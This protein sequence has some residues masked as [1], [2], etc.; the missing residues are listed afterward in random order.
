AASASA[1]FSIA[2]AI[3]TVASNDASRV[4]GQGN[5]AFSATI[6]GFVN[7]ETSQ[8]VSGSPSLSTAATL[9]SP[10]GYSAIVAG[11]GTL[12]AA[13]YTFVFKNG[14]LTVAPD[15]T[16]TAV[17][18]TVQGP[19]VGLTATVSAGAPGSGTP[20]GSVDF[21]DATTGIDLGSVALSGGS[22]TLLTS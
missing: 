5:P 22:A 21:R 16:N 14:T 2:P 1:T 10:V 18:A 17:T 11:Q 8:V 13:N 4:F 19:S 9:N 20:T 3:L 6:T 15:A 12:A 7:G